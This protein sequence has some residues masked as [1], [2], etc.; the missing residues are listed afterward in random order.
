MLL[1][2]LKKKKF[3]FFLFVF[4][5]STLSWLLLPNGKA[6]HGKTFSS[7][8]GLLNILGSNG[9][10]STKLWEFTYYILGMYKGYVKLSHMEV[11]CSA[12]RS[13]FCRCTDLK[14]LQ[15]EASARENPAS[16]MQ[17]FCSTWI[18]SSFF[19][20]FQKISQP[21]VL[22]LC[23]LPLSCSLGVL[24]KRTVLWSFAQWKWFLFYS[25]GAW[26]LSE[27]ISQLDSWLPGCPHRQRLETHFC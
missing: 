27:Y 9:S 22:S 19:Y 15:Q 18:K 2:K 1:S 14:K 11:T 20:S 24:W 26:T 7:W 8:E 3:F 4:W 10:E 12:E 25:K 13:V 23:S 6:W 21:A 5:T 16:E 17:T